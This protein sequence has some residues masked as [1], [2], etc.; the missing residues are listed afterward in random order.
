MPATGRRILPSFHIKRTAS[1]FEGD[2]AVDLKQLGAGR[3]RLP[4]TCCHTNGFKMGGSYE[5]GSASSKPAR[6]AAR[7]DYHKTIA[8][9]ADQLVGRA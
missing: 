5:E 3:A 6:M 7:H 2:A 1:I 8:Y 4:P 9:F